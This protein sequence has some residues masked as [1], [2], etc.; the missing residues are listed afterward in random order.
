MKR[1][2]YDRD[3]LQETFVDKFW[4]GEI[5]IE[6]GHIYKQQQ[7]QERRMHMAGGDGD[8]EGGGRNDKLNRESGVVRIL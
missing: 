6:T 1:L 5:Q 4:L 8:R 3:P 2:C 7:Q